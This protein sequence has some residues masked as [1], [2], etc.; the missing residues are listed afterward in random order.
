MSAARPELAVATAEAP[1]LRPHTPDRRLDVLLLHH[2]QVLISSLGRMWRTPLSSALT[3][4][5]LGVAL[6]L[7]T[8]LY[9]LLEN[10]RALGE[11][12]HGKPRI[13]LFLRTGVDG[14][15]AVAV[16][17]GL[18]S[19]EQV[20]RVQT[21]T[22]QQALQEFQELSGFA[23]ALEA[24]G[25]NPL[26]A[27]LV[28]EPSAALADPDA[29]RRFA[30]TLGQRDEVD[31]AQVDI[32]WVQRLHAI[33]DIGQRGV[34]VVGTLLALGVLLIIGNT[35]RLEIE[36]RREE[37]VVIRL[38]GGTDAFVRRPFLYSGLWFGLLG[39]V[40]ALAM[41]LAS[42]MLLAAPVRVLAELYQSD[43]ALSGLGAGGSA[44]L[45]G[46]GALL[47]L[48]GAWVAVARHL[49]RMQPA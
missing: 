44:T 16:S 6:A 14:T 5:V 2:L 24:L 34:L 8:G 21:I 35:I 28:V 1:R 26:P 25:E 12:W 32:R 46:I 36:N 42:T 47:G 11:D 18:A 29:L 31:F 15:Q 4:A 33:L 30:A 27:V 45:V 48:A 22:P 38:V 40:L 43:F 49:G 13:S 37:I 39:G 10:V 41:V 9:L 19:L 23:A 7:P 20:A 3:A 17:E